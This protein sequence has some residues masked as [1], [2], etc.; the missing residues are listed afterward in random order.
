MRKISP[1]LS[2]IK[3]LQIRDVPTQIPGH[4]GHSLS[5]TT[6]K[7]HLHKVFFR[8]IPTSGS[9]DVPGISRPKTLCLGCFFGPDGGKSTFCTPLFSKKGST[10]TPLGAGSARPNP[11]M[12]APDRENPLF[13][14]VSALRGGSRPWS[15]TMVSEGARPWGRGR[16]GDCDLWRSLE[17]GLK[18]FWAESEGKD[19][20]SALNSP[21]S[22]L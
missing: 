16:S 1:K 13:L 10:P 11:K 4:P 5:K 12:G 19:G 8:D 2:C 15:Q 20:S 22:T 17:K 21:M 6:E 18:R 7:G 3:F 14:G 9:P